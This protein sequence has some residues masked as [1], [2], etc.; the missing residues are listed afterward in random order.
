MHATVALQKR[1][2]GPMVTRSAEG[3]AEMAVSGAKHTREGNG[4]QE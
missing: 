1:K 4:P 3:G 2:Q